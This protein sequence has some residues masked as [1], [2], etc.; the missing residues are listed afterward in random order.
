YKAEGRD[1]SNSPCLFFAS[2]GNLHVIDEFST[3]LLVIISL[4]QPKGFRRIA[5]SLKKLPKFLSFLFTLHFRIIG[6]NNHIGLLSKELLK[7]PIVFML[8]KKSF[9]FSFTFHQFQFPHQSFGFY[10]HSP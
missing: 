2:K 4:R 8:N 10:R 5:I 1:F 7:N 6:L 9:Y 3:F